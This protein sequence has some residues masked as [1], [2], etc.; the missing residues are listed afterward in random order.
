MFIDVFLHRLVSLCSLLTGQIK[1]RQY[2][3]WGICLA[4]NG[5]EGTETKKTGDERRARSRCNRFQCLVERLC[6]LMHRL[7]YLSCHGLSTTEF[8]RYGYVA[9]LSRIFVFRED[10]SEVIEI[11]TREIYINDCQGQIH[12]RNGMSAISPLSLA[13]PFHFGIMIEFSGCN[14]HES[15]FVSTSITRAKSRFKYERSCNQNHNEGTIL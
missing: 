14:M 5:R 10:R 9:F 6:Q 13:S 8:F 4:L 7:A 2:I 12:S 11:L 15:G 1:G 3:V